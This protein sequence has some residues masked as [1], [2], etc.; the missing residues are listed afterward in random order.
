MFLQQCSQNVIFN[1]AEGICVVQ[2]RLLADEAKSNQSENSWRWTSCS[3]T[4]Q[5]HA[6]FYSFFSAVNCLHAHSYICWQPWRNS[7]KL[8]LPVLP[9]P[10]CWALVVG[11]F[12]FFYFPKTMCVNTL[13]VVHCVSLLPNT[14]SCMFTLAKEC[15]WKICLKLFQSQ[16]EKHT[17]T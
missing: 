7:P 11:T 14:M 3:T 4:C 13:M 2:E 10:H 5:I 9:K 8:Q 1:A 17:C 16:C 15:S 6:N 12:V